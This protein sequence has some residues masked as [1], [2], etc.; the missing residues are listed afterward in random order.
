MNPAQA[1]RQT[2]SEEPAAKVEVPPGAERFEPERFATERERKSERIEIEEPEREQSELEQGEFDDEEDI[3]RM[4]VRVLSRARGRIREQPLTA[5]AGAFLLGF[6][7][8]NGVP[9]FFA[10]AG[11]AIGLRMVMQRMF[12]RSEMFE[13]DN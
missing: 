7:V 10:R 6:A 13:S 8:G 12:E 1:A 2:T 11:I 4:T 3:R 5:A 9:K